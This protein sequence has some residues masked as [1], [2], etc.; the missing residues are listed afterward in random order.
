MRG[1]RPPVGH[2]GR[3][4]G[5]GCGGR[6]RLPS[7][8]DG[9]A[10]RG[11]RDARTWASAPRSSRRRRPCSSRASSRTSRRPRCTTTS[12]CGP[13]SCAANTARCACSCATCSACRPRFARPVRD[14]GGRRARPRRG[15]RPDVVHPHP[16]GPSTIAGS[17]ALGW[18]TPEGYRELLVERCVGRR[19]RGRRRRSAGLAARRAVAAARWVCRST[20]A[21]CRTS[22]RSRSL[23]A[24]APDGARIGTLANV[25]IHPVALGPEC[26][27]VSSDWVG[28]FRSG[29]RARA[30]RHRRCCCPA[31]SA[32]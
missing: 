4:T 19:A 17:D 15:R 7:R 21:A 1:E 32:T 26:L 25:A 22:R 5:R 24:I 28:P 3:R 30:G 12:R 13:C 31:R 8:G 23:D 20:G 6:G 16:R 11:S 14:V 29:A 2:R 10:R 9:R 18:V 27:A